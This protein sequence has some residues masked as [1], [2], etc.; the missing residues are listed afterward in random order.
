M[1]RLA[2]GASTPARHANLTLSCFC[3]TNPTCRA[4]RIGGTVR[5]TSD[6]GMAALRKRLEE[7][8]AATAAAHGCTAEVRP[9]RLP[10]P[11]PADCRSV[12][13]PSLAPLSALQA[14]HSLG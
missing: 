3:P 6:A 5:H 14:T 2:H 8:V 9:R 1:Q 7:T 13:P 11:D 4:V 12:L 10:G